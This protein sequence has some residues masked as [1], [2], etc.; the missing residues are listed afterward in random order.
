MHYAYL[1]IH[2][3]CLLA[4]KNNII[5]NE[6][7]RDSDSVFVNATEVLAKKIIIY[8][9]YVYDYDEAQMCGQKLNIGRDRPSLKGHD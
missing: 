3:C 9:T 1:Y 4:Y 6:N 5:N 8:N 7:T 2:T